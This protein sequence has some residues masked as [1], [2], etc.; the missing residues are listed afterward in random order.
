MLRGEHYMA[1]E[2]RDISIANLSGLT[3]G[4]ADHGVIWRDDNAAGWGWFVD[5]TSGNDSHFTR[6]GNQR[7]PN[8]MDSFTVLT[9]PTLLVR[10]LDAFG[11]GDLTQ[12]VGAKE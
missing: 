9:A 4:W 11:F 1:R 5:R 3:M 12:P 6:R 7:E 2:W 10:D 8:R